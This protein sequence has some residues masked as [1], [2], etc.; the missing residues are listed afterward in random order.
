[1][2]FKAI[3][4]AKGCVFHVRPAVE[5]ELIPA[6][7]PHAVEDAVIAIKQQCGIN[8]KNIRFFWPEGDSVQ[9]MIGVKLTFDTPD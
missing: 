8:P 2:Q 7:S 6:M 5:G 3:E 1:M 4:L 9:D